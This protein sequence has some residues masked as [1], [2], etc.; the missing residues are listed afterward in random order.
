MCYWAGCAD[1]SAEGSSHCWDP[2]VLASPVGVFQLWTELLQ[3]VSYKAE[4]LSHW[5]VGRQQCLASL[6]GET[7]GHLDIGIYR[8]VSYLGKDRKFFFNYFFLSAA[9]VSLVHRILWKIRIRIIL[10]DAGRY[11]S[12]K[13]SLSSGSAF[14]FICLFAFYGKMPSCGD[15]CERFGG[16]GLTLT[17][18]HLMLLLD[19]AGKSSIWTSCPSSFWSNSFPLLLSCLPRVFHDL[20]LN[21]VQIQHLWLLYNMFWAKKTF[22]LK[23]QILWTSPSKFTTDSSPCPS[24][25]ADSCFLLSTGVDLLHFSV[26]TEEDKLE[27]TACTDMALWATSGA[28]CCSVWEQEEA[29]SY[30]I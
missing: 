20:P 5:G 27:Y 13:S 6:P 22:P 17:L 14:L 25:W 21:W 18:P 2:S 16:L 30:N 9:H 4:E 7:S 12:K 29:K 28:V 19:P 11:P 23:S 3:Q 8:R 15:C 24:L 10:A 1:T 26:S